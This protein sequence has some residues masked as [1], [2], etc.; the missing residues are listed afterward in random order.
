M[1]LE[2]R[3]NRL[4][5]R[6]AA[7][8]EVLR[9]LMS[10]SRLADA[11]SAPSPPAPPPPQPSPPSHRVPVRPEE[12]SPPGPRGAR[13]L[14][15]EEWIGQRGLLA[16]GVVALILAA[17]YLLKLSFERNWISPLMRC[18]GGAMGGIGVGALGWRLE[19]RYRTYGASLIGC[20]AAI[21]Y[22]SVWAASRL[23]GIRPPMPGIL[24]LALVSLSL[25]VIADSLGVEALGTTA[26]V[27]A[28]IA[29]I[30]LG[31]ER[32]NADLLL[33]YLACMTVALGWVAARRHWRLTASVMAFGYFGLAASAA[34]QARPAGLLLYGV[35]GGSAGLAL[36]LRDRWWETRFLSFWGGWG[37]IASAADRMPQQR[38]LLIAATALAA[39]VWWYAWRDTRPWLADLDPKNPVAKW[40]L[41]ELLYFFAL[42][43]L[44]GWAI[45]RQS[46]NGF[47]GSPG[48]PAFL[49]AVPYV[50][51]GYLGRKPRFALVGAAAAAVAAWM[52]WPGLPATWALLALAVL[53]TALDHS[54]GRTDGRWY[55]L[56]T[57]L[58][59][60]V[61]LCDTDAL[62]RRA[63]EPA[64]T[65]PWALALW[66]LTLIT[67]AFA[68]GL[69]KPSARREESAPIR[70]GLW[71]GAGALALGGVTAEIGRYFAQGGIPDASARLASGL[72]VSTWWLLF[73][74]ALVVLGL[75]RSIKG[76]R[77]AG[78]RVA[79]GAM[80]KVLVY[81]LASLDALY[82]VASVFILGLV[83]LSLAYLYHRRAGVQGT[84]VR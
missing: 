47:D 56:V 6:L 16:V 33:V 14:E 44:L 35:V 25:A 53:W 64:F 15:S 82:R 8:E 30:L 83:S 73:A 13:L 39:P 58:A 36:G 41:G 50:L 38:P 52:E 34:T 81:D 1:N 20:G 77:V 45:S 27:G 75:Q 22:L 69:W 32:A 60:L 65:G 37:L 11:P 78:L 17:G 51:A 62:R 59:A 18:A 70:A 61:H 72:A 67:L 7:V 28:C 54:L 4:E 68:L 66:A 26:A 23:Y 2:P 40:S 63:T 31:R 12:A 48:A 9:Q 43:V 21:I 10:A 84:R 80:L 71:I 46:P 24:G 76:S 5:E 29:P 79:G 42:P 49:V 55:G 74:A 3:L 19:R 57:L